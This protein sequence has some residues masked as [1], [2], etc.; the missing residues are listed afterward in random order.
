MVRCGPATVQRR[1]TQCTRRLQGH[2]Q[3][4][5][6]HTQ[7]PVTRCLGMG[8][9]S[10]PPRARQGYAFGHDLNKARGRCG[11]VERGRCRSEDDAACATSGL[12]VTICRACMLRACNNMVA[13][14]PVVQY[15]KIGLKLPL[16]LL[17]YF[18]SDAWNPAD[19]SGRWICGCRMQHTRLSLIDGV[20]GRLLAQASCV[21]HTNKLPTKGMPKRPRRTL[22]AGDARSQR[23]VQHAVSAAQ[24]A[25]SA[26]QANR[27]VSYMFTCRQRE[28][29][30]DIVDSSGHPWT[31]RGHRVDSRGHVRVWTAPPLGEEGN[32]PR[33]MFVAHHAQCRS[34]WRAFVAR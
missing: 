15:P 24:H 16:H 3:Y 19:M 33:V 22:S 26:S 8:V 23:A 5:P 20:A 12:E 14:F 28:T 34:G 13:A 21:H 32:F 27:P 2:S 29:S 30:V 4:E 25:V 10:R 11:W 6:V 18:H 1:N 7:P 9:D 17:S 31:P